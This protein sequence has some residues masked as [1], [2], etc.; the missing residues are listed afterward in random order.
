[1]RK[2]LFIAVTAATAL[3][4]GLSAVPA[5]AA[6]KDVLTTG[7]VGGTNVRDGA[8][9]K[10]NLKS[11]STANFI[12]SGTKSTGVKCKKSSFSA[13]VTSNPKKPG[14]AKESL[15]AQSFSSC[16]SNV[17]D[18]KSIKSVKLSNLPNKVSSSDKKG[19]P[20]TVSESS[21]SKPLKTTVVLNTV[22][23][24]VTCVYTAKSLS[25]HG[26]NSGNTITFTNQKLSKSSGPSVCFKTGLFSATYGPLEDSSA[27]N[28]KVFIN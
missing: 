13:K 17:Q 25:G 11:G 15:T 26:S 23:G 14:T 18:V 6:T 20:V 7:K 28:A 9:L 1:M 5:S 2:Y 3:L 4:M 12:K 10:A 19:F 21:S 8:T 24:S 22:L 27:G 16:T